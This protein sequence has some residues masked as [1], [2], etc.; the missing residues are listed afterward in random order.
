MGNFSHFGFLTRVQVN[1][2]IILFIAGKNKL[3]CPHFSGPDAGEPSS[4]KPDNIFDDDA[5]LLYISGDNPIVDIK[6]EVPQPGYYVLVA[7]Y[8]QPD[9]SSKKT[10][11]KKK[12][13]CLQQ[14][15]TYPYPFVFQA[16]IWI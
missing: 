9:E 11:K 5:K 4:L 13:K 12:S 1:F 14:L 7:N 2:R 10:K 15:T 6:G 8:Y 3:F 16:S